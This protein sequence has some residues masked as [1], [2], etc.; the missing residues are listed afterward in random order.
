[1][2]N[3]ILTQNAGQATMTQ[4][5]KS[6]AEDPLFEVPSIVEF[7][8]HKFESRIKQTDGS[9]TTYRFSDSGIQQ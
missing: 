2:V 9:I 5:V 8:G 7:G 4:E 3:V 6:F 1:M